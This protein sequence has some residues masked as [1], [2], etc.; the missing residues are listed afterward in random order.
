MKQLT[1]RKLPR[2]THTWVKLLGT[3][4]ITLSSL[5]VNYT[6]CNRDLRVQV[7][8]TPQDPCTDLIVAHILS[9]KALILVQA[10]V[11]TSYEIANALI[12]AHRNRIKVQVLIDKD[13]QHTKGSKVGLLLQHGIPVIIDKTVGCAHNK[14]MIID[15][16]HVITGSFNWTHSAQTRNAEN[17]EIITGKEINRQFKNNWYIRAAA[18]KRLRV[19]PNH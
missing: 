11:I 17:L 1:N 15:D 18:G 7:Y 8:F 6:A 14:I 5:F 9:A 3:A 19:I 10:Y 2:I 12:K 13:A 4:I 16:T